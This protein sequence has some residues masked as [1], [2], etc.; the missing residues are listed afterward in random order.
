MAKLNW[1][2]S[3]GAF[4]AT[5]EP[6][7]KVVVRQNKNVVE[8]EILLNGK[9]KKRGICRDLDFGKTQAANEVTEYLNG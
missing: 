9:W 3:E 6:G 2:E 8:W 5:P 1:T 7:V 4:T